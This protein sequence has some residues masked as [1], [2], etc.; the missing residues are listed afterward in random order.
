MELFRFIAPNLGSFSTSPMVH[1]SPVTALKDMSSLRMRPPV[2]IRG[3]GN[4][5]MISI[6][7]ASISVLACRYRPDVHSK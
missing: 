2:A 1:T 3:I 5:L 4:I 6:L 7:S